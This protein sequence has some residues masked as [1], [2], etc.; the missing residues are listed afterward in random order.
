MSAD[1]PRPEHRHHRDPYPGF[2]VDSD[3]T[4]A[5]VPTTPERALR[6]LRDRRHV[7]G[8][9]ALG[10]ACGSLAR[11]G[12]AEALPHDP[13]RFPWSTLVVN[14]VGCFAIGV[15]MVLVMERWPH[16]SLVRPFFG[17]GVLGGFTTFSTYAV[18]GRSLVAA[19]RPA[20]AGA[21]LVATLLLGLLAVIAG[22]RTAERALR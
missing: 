14:V 19:G 11:W 9:I 5:D 16:R 13:D 4:D 12:V 7:L 18:D 10:G 8:V 17:T 20:L 22:L 2:P 3:V 1:D 6:L 21:Y 15:V